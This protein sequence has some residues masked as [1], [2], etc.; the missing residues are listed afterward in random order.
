MIE[1]YV[2]LS[3]E[4]H[5]FF[6]RIMKEHSL[7]LEAGFPCKNKDWIEE[8]D[9]FRQKFEELLSDV[10]RL[11]DGR[12]NRPILNSNELV[13]EFTINAERR[14]EQ[15]SGV[16]IDTDLSVR[17]KNL[18][19]ISSSENDRAVFQMVHRIN[20]RSIHLLNSLI[21]FKECILKEV[22]NGKL[23]TANYPLLIEHILREAKLYRSTIDNLMHNRQ[24]SYTGLFG[25]EEFWN[26]IMME[27]ALFIR[28]LLDPCEEDLIKTAHEFA[29][30]YKKLLEMAKNQDCAAMQAFNG[31]AL[32]ETLKYRDFKAAG[33][34]GI[35]N[36][37]IDSIILPLL[38]DHVLREANHYIRILKCSNMRECD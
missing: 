29:I 11:S 3:L 35:L 8:A 30:D 25:T 22:K 33:T 16:S 15:L 37:D 10:I 14:T 27:H 24:V 2:T 12:V 34:K 21:D 4:T 32:E 23:F 7:F 18:R 1:N 9:N 17:T 20:E 13:T 19:S 36:C 6:S 5:L 38:A 26:R 31:E 28:G